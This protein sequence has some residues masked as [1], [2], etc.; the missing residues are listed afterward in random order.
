MQFRKSR[1]TLETL[2][3]HTGCGTLVHPMPIKYSKLPGIYHD[4]QGGFKEAIEYRAYFSNLK[5]PKISLTWAKN[6]S[7]LGEYS[8]M[9]V[10]IYI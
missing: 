10:V 9:I 2:W 1:G 3:R 7:P 4:G 6:L 5:F 8:N